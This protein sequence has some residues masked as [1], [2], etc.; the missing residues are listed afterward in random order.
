M[1]C[2]RSTDLDVAAFLAG[3]SSPGVEEF[4]AH[5]PSC[6][7]CS[8]AVRAWMTLHGDLDPQPPLRQHPSEELLLH[9]ESEPDEM[10]AVA[11]SSVETH[12]K[13][14][15]SC[16]DELRALRR[17]DFSILQQ[18]AT[19]ASPADSREEKTKRSR[20]RT[21]FAPAR[22]ILLH[23]AFAYGLVLLLLLPQL[24]T[25]LAR[26]GFF[27]PQEQPRFAAPTSS[28]SVRARAVIPPEQKLQ[29][30][31]EAP[32]AESVKPETQR[33][34][35]VAAVID[36]EMLRYPEPGGEVRERAAAP[37][38]PPVV[39]RK[40][41]LDSLAARKV[42]LA[43]VAESE[44][45]GDARQ[46]AEEQALE[47]SLSHDA[48][49][50]RTKVVT[51]QMDPTGRNNIP[52]EGMLDGAILHIKPQ[53]P[54]SAGS[55]VAIRIKSSDGRRELREIH[56]AS[57]KDGY[58]DMT[59]PP[60]WMPDGVYSVEVWPLDAMPKNPWQRHEHGIESFR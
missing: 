44:Q 50:K 31:P 59:I 45:A 39:Q 4:R 48:A 24:S 15:A 43:N 58:L 17:F 18:P 8:A 37:E 27:N 32:L 36:D 10:S 5:Y 53:Q 9:F 55:D 41:T 21:F 19:D 49:D 22:Q 28:E 3:E 56:T 16:R 52:M 1:K 38:P 60:G 57:A 35:G 33:R 54:V 42:P 23:P 29:D 26:P 7:E 12:L 46:A 13:S 20:W 25:L 47:R 34:E 14:C 2:D 11:R 40:R 30:A 6:P 51:I